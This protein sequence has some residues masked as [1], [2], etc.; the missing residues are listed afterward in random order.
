MTMMIDT[1]MGQR[2]KWL[3]HAASMVATSGQNEEEREYRQLVVEQIAE[4]I[5]LLMKQQPSQHSMQ[6]GTQR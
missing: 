6:D 5:A 1:D 2:M 4:S 3:D